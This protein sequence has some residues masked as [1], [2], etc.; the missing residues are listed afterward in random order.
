MR[1]LIEVPFDKAEDGAT[2]LT[3]M[4]HGWISGQWDSKTQTCSA[5]YWRDMEWSPYA[6]YMITKDQ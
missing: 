1:K 6:L 3:E 5:Y 2:Y 4:K